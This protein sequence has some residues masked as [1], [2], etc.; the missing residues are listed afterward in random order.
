MECNVV[1]IQLRDV[2]TLCFMPFVADHNC[3]AIQRRRSRVVPVVLPVSPAVLSLPSFD[4]RGW[5]TAKLV[6]LT[7]HLIY[8]VVFICSSVTSPLRDFSPLRKLWGGILVHAGARA[9]TCTNTLMDLRQHVR[10]IERDFLYPLMCFSTGFAH[11]RG[12]F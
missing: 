6:P 3:A 12:V 8:S 9:I 1:V 11:C 7:W 5:P 2:F 4:G 10:L